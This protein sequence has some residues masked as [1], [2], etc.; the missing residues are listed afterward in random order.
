MQPTENM[1]TFLGG[2]GGGGGQRGCVRVFFL[3]SDVDVL[4]DSRSFS[5][6][7]VGVTF[8][9][10]LILGAEMSHSM[11]G[12]CCVCVFFFK[13][14]PA[15]MTIHFQKRDMLNLS[16]LCPASISHTQTTCAHSSS[17]NDS[18]NVPHQRMSH[19]TTLLLWWFLPSVYYIMQARVLLGYIHHNKHTPSALISQWRDPSSLRGKHYFVNLSSHFSYG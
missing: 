11:T 8:A 2:G 3:L 10:D 7:Q 6:S 4:F 5:F 18:V 15:Q 12:T 13:T 1:L 16:L 14:S 17:L 9:C 19:S